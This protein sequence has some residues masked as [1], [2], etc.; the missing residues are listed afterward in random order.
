MQVHQL[1]R[2]IAIT[3]FLVPAFA[4]WVISDIFAATAPSPSA[5]TIESP[6]GRIRLTVRVAEQSGHQRITYEASFDARPVLAP[7]ITGHVRHDGVE[8]GTRLSGI[9]IGTVT[10]HQETWKP[11]YGERSVVEDNYKA[12]VINAHDDLS[13]ANL[14]YVFR[15]YDAGIA[16]MVEIAGSTGDEPVRLASEATE[17][18]FHGDHTAWCTLKAQGQYY[19]CKLSGI[20]S[21]AE[22][23]LVLQVEKDLYA[24][25]MEARLVDYA[26]MKLRTFSGKPHTLISSLEGG[27]KSP[28][29]LETPWR[30]VMI[31][32][33]P[34]ELLEQNDLVLNLNDPCEI[35]DTSWITPGKILREVTLTNTGARACIDFAAAN[36][37][38]YVEFDAGWYGPEDDE[39]SD[40]AN[41]VLDPA[42]SSGPFDLQEILQYAEERGVKTILYVNRRALER[43]LDELLPLFQSWGVAGIK[44]GFVRVGSQ[45]WTSWLHEAVRKCADYQLMVDV[46]DEYRPTGYSRT[47]PNLMTQEG[48]RGDEEGDTATQAVRTLFTRGL[49]GAMD[50]TVC[51]F[52]SRV[53][54]QWSRAHQLAKSVCSYSPWQFIYWYDR[55]PSDANPSRHGTVIEPLPELVFFRHLPVVWDDTRVLSGEIDKWAVIA[56]R[57]GDDWFVGAMNG[58]EATSFTV[59]LTF[60]RDDKTYIAEIYT[61]S[62]TSDAPHRVAIEQRKVNSTQ[63]LEIQMR[64]NGGQA[65]RLVPVEEGAI[66]KDGADDPKRV[67]AASE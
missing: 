55:P 62:P 31:A 30:V 6:N 11:V 47:Y 13:E 50:R 4:G 1:R 2:C 65:F 44:F 49:V 36:N 25:V 23:P 18:S 52:D 58:E 5:V 28:G 51:Y 38:E 22:R 12:V 40:A 54:R 41:P 20:A 14:R 9:K 39:A 27:V 19:Q 66:S 33:S 43:Q 63:E 16:F 34:G 29:P 24:A 3:V 8:I 59:P 37:I 15:C 61:D 17:F 64:P 57:S 21:P 42:R 53:T 46:H 67:A 60:L 48:V 7:S 56:R 26:R 10:N 35:E 32:E 45:E